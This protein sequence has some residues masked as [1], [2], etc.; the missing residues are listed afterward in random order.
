MTNIEKHGFIRIY[1]RYFAIIR[2]IFF[3][4]YF[5]GV[6]TI[7]FVFLYGNTRNANNNPIT[8]CNR[9]TKHKFSSHI[10]LVYYLIWPSCLDKSGVG[11]RGKPPKLAMRTRTYGRL[12]IIFGRSTRQS[13]RGRPG[14]IR[15]S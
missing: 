9:V 5:V 14:I 13:N 7:Y 15:N 8:N 12:V 11:Y 2:L 6:I 4:Y 3:L 10:I 1:N